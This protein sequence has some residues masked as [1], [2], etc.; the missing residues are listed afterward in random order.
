MGKATIKD[1]AALAGVSVGTVSMALNDSVKISP[2]TK[3]SVLDA[4]DKLDYRR[5][6]FARSLSLSS[7]RSIGFLIPDLTNPFF[8]VMAGCLQQ[9][10]E[11]RKNSLMFG[12]TNESSAR[13]ARLVDQFLDHGVDGLVIVPVIEDNPDLTHVYSLLQREFPLVFLS[14]HYHAIPQHCVMADLAFGSYELTGHLLDT[15]HKRIIIVSGN[16]SLIPFK[17]RIAGFY[18][19]FQERD[20]SV[21]DSQ[22]VIADGM[23]YHGGYTAI[24]KVFD[25]LKPDAIIAIND[26]MAMGIISHLR[27]NGIR[28]PEDVS[29]AGFD[30]LSISAI[31]ETPLTTVRQPL[32]EM[33]SQAIEMLFSLMESRPVPDLPVKLPAPVMYRKSTRE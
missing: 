32:D 1:V 7:S 6:P 31:Q 30:D 21:D 12:L 33:C 10:V 27:A 16:R 13:E 8:G 14:S 20:I 25:V 3:Q 23:S 15:G 28:V 18:R 22:I 17:E 11:A 29:V 2:K 26:V 5:N 4:V 9:S 24:A 19:A